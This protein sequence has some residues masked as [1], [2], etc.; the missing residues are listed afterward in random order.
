MTHSN[1]LAICRGTRPTRRPLSTPPR[2]TR[3]RRDG[4]LT[5]VRVRNGS[6]ATDASANSASPTGLQHRSIGPPQIQSR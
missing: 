4:H 2:L 6:A 5:D 1:A 3:C